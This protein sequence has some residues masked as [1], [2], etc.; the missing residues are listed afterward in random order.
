MRSQLLLTL[1]VAGPLAAALALPA[2]AAPCDAY[3]GGCPTAGS[4]SFPGGGAG[5]GG[6]QGS[7]TGT[8]SGSGGTTVSGGRVSRSTGAGADSG[9]GATLPFTGGETVLYS[10]IGLGAVGAGT[11]LVLAGRKRPQAG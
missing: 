10:L 3:S 8:V 2:S 11:A 9:P 5:G 6:A 7:G 4:D 1:V